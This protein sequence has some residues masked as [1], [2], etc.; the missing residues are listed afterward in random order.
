MN[1]L[2]LRNTYSIY[3]FINTSELPNWIYSSDFY[4]ITRSEDELSVVAIQNLSTPT[5][6][7]SDPG[8]RILKIAGPLDFSL[9]GIIAEISAILKEKNIPIFVISTFETDFILVKN[10]SLKSAIDT[11]INKGHIVTTQH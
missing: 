3:S 11:L 10:G 2:V 5:N 7:K 9:I 8:W 6:V 1:F 4:S